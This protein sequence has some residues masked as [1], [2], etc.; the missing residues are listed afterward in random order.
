[1]EPLP[2]RAPSEFMA[3][4][5][6]V[7]AWPGMGGDQ[8]LVFL[9]L[10]EIAGG[11]NRPVVCHPR[12]IAVLL[13]RSEKSSHRYLD[14]LAEYGLMEIRNRE[15]HRQR[16]AGGDW[17]I[18]LLDPREVA[19]MRLMP[20]E[21]AEQPELDFWSGS[22]S[23]TD[24]M[25]EKADVLSLEGRSPPAEN[26]APNAGEPRS[27]V[28]DSQ[29]RTS[30]IPE[31]RTSALSA[32]VESAEVRSSDPRTADL[33]QETA[34]TFA[35]SNDPRSA[36]LGSELRSA[37]LIPLRPL[38]PLGLKGRAQLGPCTFKPLKGSAFFDAKTADLR[39]IQNSQEKQRTAEEDQAAEECGRLAGA[40]GEVMG[41]LPSPREREKWVNE[42]A[43]CILEAV[44]DARLFR[45]VALKFAWAMANGLIDEMDLES[46]LRPMRHTQ[47]TDDVTPSS[48]F[49]KSAMRMFERRGLQWHRPA[50]K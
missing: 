11:V 31:L 47:T 23:P 20:G 7:M 2:Q 12:N 16:R 5:R 50:R 18:F 27:A 15:T 21:S 49:V 29:P 41:K 28:L 10:L 45:G 33:P 34:Q 1:M 30:A 26:S 6:Q 4:R 8:K 9:Y 24:E 48:Y 19:R 42:K 35:E 13:G 38:R 22:Q 46:I 25:E 44:G 39:R 43:D 36:V 3:V 40:I 14:R 32:Q 37:P 17:T